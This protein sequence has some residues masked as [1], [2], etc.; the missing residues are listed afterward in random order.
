[1]S[2]PYV[3]GITGGSGSGKTRFMESLMRE[4]E[5]ASLLSMDH[6][7]V[8]IEQQEKDDQ[9]IEDFDRLESIDHDKYV[10]DLKRLMSGESISFPEYTFNNSDT[11][12]KEITVESKPIILVEGIFVLYV[13]E[14]R[15][16]LDLKLYIEAPDYLMMKRRIV[17]DAKERGY[18]LED[19]LYRYEH[20][21]APSYKKYIEPSKKWADL[22]IPNHK[23]FDVALKV[24]T[25]FLNR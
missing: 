24:I 18:D 20:H 7:Y 22:V 21:V 17:R 12:P 19:V 23:D 16:L 15:S 13:P 6:Y 4:T 10:K 5:D 8:N 3:V 1:M 14:I 11:N 25:T 9:G 2:K